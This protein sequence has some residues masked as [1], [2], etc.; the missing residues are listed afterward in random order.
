MEATHGVLEGAEVVRH[1]THIICN[2]DYL[3]V[4]I[5]CTNISSYDLMPFPS[6]GLVILR[7][8]GGNHMRAMFSLGSGMNKRAAGVVS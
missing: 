4:V 7:C 5:V 1:V 3:F 6:L 8:Y 2:S